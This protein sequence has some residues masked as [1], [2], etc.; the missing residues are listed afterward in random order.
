MGRPGIHWV[1]VYLLAL[2]L[3]NRDGSLPPRSILPWHREQRQGAVY[4]RFLP[5]PLLPLHRHPD[6]VVRDRCAVEEPRKRSRREPGIRGPIVPAPGTD[7]VN[8]SA[9]GRKMLVAH[10]P[11]EVVVTYP[12]VGPYGGYYRS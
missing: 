6:A 7:G 10:R 2:R 1:R 3:S 4:G 5:I 12:A 8:G 9:M 11:G